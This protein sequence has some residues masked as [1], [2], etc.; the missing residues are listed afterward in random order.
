[1]SLGVH[2]GP[3]VSSPA[4]RPGERGMR[5]LLLQSANPGGGD[6]RFGVNKPQGTPICLLGAWASLWGQVVLR[7]TWVYAEYTLRERF[8]QRDQ[9]RG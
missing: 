3:Q 6:P 4:G 1:M 2:P 5:H 9:G 7:C 8:V